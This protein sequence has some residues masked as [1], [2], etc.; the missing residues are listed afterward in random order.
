[1]A[2][3]TGIALPAGRLFIN[4]N[5]GEHFMMQIV[6][7]RAIGYRPFMAIACMAFFI[8]LAFG[9]CKKDKEKGVTERLM[10]KW[11]LVQISDT[12]Y[13]T[14]ASP[15]ITQYPG[16]TGEFLDFNKNGK[17][18]SFIKNA[19]DSANYTYSEANFKVNVKDFR[20]NILIL[21]DETM[22]LYEPHY[23]TSTNA[24]TAYKITLQR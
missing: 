24:Y 19:L 3:S 8:L 6:A 15:V 18:Y 10:N 4:Q 23:T 20:Y 11:N 16:K 12:A 2:K 21:T 14:G 1:M 9:A 5:L 7:C 13:A 17:L 22:I